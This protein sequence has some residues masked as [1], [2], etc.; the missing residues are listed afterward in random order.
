MELLN[1]RVDLIVCS[2]RRQREDSLME[3]GVWSSHKSI[4][5]SGKV[6][7][8]GSGLKHNSSWNTI[9]EAPPDLKLHLNEQ[10]VQPNLIVQVQL[11]TWLSAAG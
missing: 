3:V 11:R 5:T 10:R 9:F 1:T 4:T 2:S 6:S 7:G 8:N